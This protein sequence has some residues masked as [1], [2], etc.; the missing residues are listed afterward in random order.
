[1][2]H[3]PTKIRV[4]FP[5]V[6]DS[7]G[8]SYI[9]AVGIIKGLSRSCIEPVVAL[10]Q[11]GDLSDYLRAH[12]VPYKLLSHSKY[13]TAR[14]SRRVF[15]ELC[16]IVPPLAWFLR[17]QAIDIVHTNDVRMYYTWAVPTVLARKKFLLH[18]RV[19]FDEV[20]GGIPDIYRK[21]MSKAHGVICDSEYVRHRLKSGLNAPVRTLRSSIDWDREAPD[22]GKAKSEMLVRIAKPEGTSVIGFFANFLARKR[23]FVFVETA[24]RIARS[25]PSPV[26]FVMFGVDRGLLSEALYT[27][28][29][30]R[31]IRDSLHIMGF[32]APVEPL[33]AGCDIMIAPAVREPLGLTLLEGCFV[34]TPVIAADDAGHREIYGFVVP[35]LLA[36]PDDPQAFCDVALGLLHDR[37]RAKFIVER[38]RADLSGRFGMPH[39]VASIETMYRELLR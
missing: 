15:A 33:M 31:G 36:R 14:E 4:L 7:V 25:Y 10:H 16:S 8:G 37:A 24:A 11:L 28:A 23:P 26:A 19:V 1:M 6:G 18:L 2:N 30:A 22:R 21:L 9:M 38:A 20:P 34:G 17:K 3:E 39:Y 5:F 13:L 35:E 12:G 32:A 27:L 29:G